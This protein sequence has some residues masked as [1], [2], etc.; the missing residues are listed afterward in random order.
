LSVNFISSCK[1]CE[2]AYLIG[3]L[4]LKIAVLNKSHKINA[5]KTGLAS[6]CVNFIDFWETKDKVKMCK[7]IF[8]TFHCRVKQ[9][10]QLNPKM[11]KNGHAK[12]A[13]AARGAKTVLSVFVLC[14]KK[15]K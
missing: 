14:D 12:I 11:M 1:W 4:C 6:K 8:L 15:I 7:I 5:Q 9:Y 13:L 3:A 2:P 10:C